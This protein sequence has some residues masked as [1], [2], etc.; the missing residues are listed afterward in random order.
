MTSY[1]TRLSRNFSSKELACP[2]CGTCDVS[3]LLVTRLQ[4]LR[5]IVKRPLVVNSGFRCKK[6]NEEIQGQKFSQHLRGRA[7]DISTKDFTPEALDSLHKL[8]DSM[9]EGFGRYETFVH[10]DVR[11]GPSARWGIGY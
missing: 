6:H 8:C 4:A 9:F 1:E 11:E 2:C 3:P 5:D 10:L 7:V